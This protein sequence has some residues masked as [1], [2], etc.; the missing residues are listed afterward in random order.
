MKR[1]RLAV[2]ESDDHDKLGS[3]IYLKSST[4]SVRSKKPRN[5][6]G[7]NTPEESDAET[8]HVVQKRVKRVTTGASASETPT[9]LHFWW[10]SH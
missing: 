8:Q 1:K 4:K 3:E 9:I 7:K 2:K 5:T 6:R 10:I